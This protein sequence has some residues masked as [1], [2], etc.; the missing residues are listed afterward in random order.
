VGEGDEVRVID[1]GL[2]RDESLTSLT[3]SREAFGTPDYTAPEQERGM[4]VDERADV[5]SAGQT[6][7]YMLAGQ[8]A[9]LRATG[10]VSVLE[11]RPEELPEP[12]PPGIDRV[13]R[14]ALAADPLERWESCEALREAL[15]EL[16]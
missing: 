13:L 8:V 3:H 7:Y 14:R 10:Y 1:F 12:P 2:A 9:K 11:R 5:F 16:P 15:A 6:L 4:D